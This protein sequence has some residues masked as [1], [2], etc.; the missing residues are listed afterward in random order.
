MLLLLLLLVVLLPLLLLPPLLPPPPLLLLLIPHVG[1]CRYTNIGTDD[2]S[3][4]DLFEAMPGGIEGVK[5]AVN[6]LHALGIKVLI[7]YNPWDAGTLRCGPK[8]AQGV[9]GATCGG[10]ANL[11]TETAKNGGYCNGP[12][13]AAKPG[14]C[15]A[16]IIDSLIQGA[17]AGP[18]CWPLLLLLL[19]LL[20]RPTARLP[21]PLTP[22]RRHECRRLQRRHDGQRATGV[23][24]RRARAEPQHR[25]RA[26]GWRQR[27]RWFG[28][29]GHHGV[30]LLLVVLLL[31]L[32]LVLLLLLLVVLLLLLLL[33]LLLLLLVVLL[34]LLLLLVPLALLLTLL[35][36]LRAGATG[37]TRTPRRS[38]PGSGW[39]RAA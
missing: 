25:H 6:E 37:S 7:P 8:N 21:L 11:T 34:L 10:N 30:L 12:A 26:G 1:G 3:Q 20:L 22:R 33:V 35:L 18:C 16:R 32:L 17:A 39:T 19:R 27:G 29:V 14:I 5:R 9:G 4:F 13:T 15:D 36:S 28:R 31:L 2:R 24:E 38:T 23:L